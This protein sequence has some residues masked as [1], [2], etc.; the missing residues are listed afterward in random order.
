MIRIGKN[1]NAGCER[2]KEVIFKEVLFMGRRSYLTRF[3][4]DSL[5]RSG[6]SCI[7]KERR[8]ISEKCAL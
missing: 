8:D 6:G 3:A 5:R 7:E 4:K 2:R 1:A